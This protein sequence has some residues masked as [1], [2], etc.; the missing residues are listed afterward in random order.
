MRP[1]VR[2][3]AVCAIALVALGACSD[4]GREMSPPRADQRESVATTT[5]LDPAATTTEVPALVPGTDAAAAPSDAVRFVL[6]GPWPDGGPIDPAATC[7]GADTSPALR[8][9]GVPEA[10]S[11]FALVVTDID[12]LDDT[13][14][15]F[16]HWVLANISGDVTAIEQGRAP[17]G[18]IEAL[19]SFGTQGWRG[20]CP[21]PGGSHRYRFALHALDQQ[22]D[23]PSGVPGADLITAIEAATLA[24]TVYEGVYP[25][26]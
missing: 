2:L 10:T 26:A 18:T 3:L 15:P 24:S 20:P 8:W 12:A 1:S 17:D 9:F 13:G 16:V 5:T 4:D 22:L 21:P 11:T 19:N 6:A 14:Q 25:S 7:D 23:L